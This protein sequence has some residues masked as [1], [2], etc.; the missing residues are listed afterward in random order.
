MK[1]LWW[2]Q[3]HESKRLLAIFTLWMTI[4]AL[5]AIG[6]ELGH[7]YRAIVGHFSGLAGFYGLF[8]S[9]VLAMRAA[10][11]EQTDGTM[12]FS[13]ALP[14]STRRMG[15]VRIVAAIATLAIP[16]LIAAAILSIALVSGLVTQGEPRT[17]ENYLRLPERGLASLPTSIEQLASVAA[18]DIM[19]SVQLLLVL[20][21][22]GYSL[23]SQA[24]V[25]LMGAV[26]G[27]AMRIASGLFW[28]GGGAGNAYAQL[29]YG[30]FLPQ[31]LSA[32]WGFRDGTGGYCDIELVKYRWIAIGLALPLFVILGRLFVVGYGV[33]RR[34]SAAKPRRFRISTPAL[35]SHFP[36]PLPGRLS[37]MIW[38]ELRQSVPLATFGL[39]FAVLMSIASVLM[40]HSRLEHGFGT[41]VLM[42]MP[43]SM[44]VIGMLWAVVVGSGLYSSDLESRL[45]TFWRSRPISPGMWFWTKFM[46]G[47]VAVLGVLDGV[48]ILV[49]WNAP[50]DGMTSGMSWA[51]VGCFPI[52]HAL[53]YSLAVLGTCWFR[54]PVIGGILA[55]LGYAVLTVWI[56]AFPMTNHLEPVHVHNNLLA[57]ER[58]LSPE[59]PQLDFTQHGYPLVYGTLA[60]STFLLALLSSRLAKPLEPT[61]RWFRP[62]DS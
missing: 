49:S 53:M 55:I 52:L 19:G 61:S 44:F 41:S 15:T 26:L 27:T 37:A 18:I 39:L 33:T 3:W 38:L 50:R 51:Y 17:P 2:K 46:I 9:I 36:I 32:H 16:I 34:S 8:A 35:L 56:G 11:G 25:G 40:E 22:L 7:H 20:S 6:Y 24:Q 10:R 29:I 42:D 13:E 58:H 14:I 54:K 45:G 47:L 62:L 21:L 57:S 12:S 23:R 59:A 1:S 31:A 48:T 4:A 43:H 60:A 5:Y 30:T 28:T